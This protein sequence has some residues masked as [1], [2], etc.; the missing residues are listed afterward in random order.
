MNICYRI[1]KDPVTPNTGGS[2]QRF[3]FSLFV[4]AF[5]LRLLLREKQSG[6]PRTEKSNRNFIFLSCNESAGRWK[7]GLLIDERVIDGYV[8]EPMNP[9][10][11]NF[12]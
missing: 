4:I 5:L 2:V 12:L 9:I 7:G 6:F 8:Q 3:G 1:E 11:L 10:W